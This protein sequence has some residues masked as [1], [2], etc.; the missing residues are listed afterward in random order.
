MNLSADVLL[1]AAIGLL[2]VT[3]FL[4]AL[5]AMD[6]YKLVRLRAVA[7]VIVLRRT[8]PELARP[9]RT[10]WYPV[11]PVIFMVL[12]TIAWSVYSWLLVVRKELAARDVQ[13]ARDRCLRFD[14]RQRGLDVRKC[15]RPSMR[16][17]SSTAS[18]C[19]RI[20][21]MSS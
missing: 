19:T 9:Y 16:T 21:V 7:G 10:P 14:S 1:R 11:V 6:S 3:V 12:A 13:H 8:H 4:V 20:G 5:M 15:H 18:E 17:E 2:P